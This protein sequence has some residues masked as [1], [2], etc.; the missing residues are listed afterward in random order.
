MGIAVGEKGT[1][2]WSPFPHSPWRP[3]GWVAGPPLQPMGSEKAQGIPHRGAAQPLLTQLRSPP[4][5][6]TAWPRRG[7]SQSAGTGSRPRCLLPLRPW[8]ARRRCCPSLPRLCF[9][10]SGS[11]CAGCCCALLSSSS[12]FLSSSSGSWLSSAAPS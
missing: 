12:S 3:R 2:M 6:P 7:H 11:A 1:V 10:R 9:P 4:H 8:L 5:L